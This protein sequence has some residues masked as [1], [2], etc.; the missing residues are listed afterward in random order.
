[1]QRYILGLS[2]VALTYL[3]GKALNLR[4]GC[5]LVADPDKPMVR[6][7]VFA[8]GTEKPFDVDHNTA[9]AYA[10]EAAKAFGVGEDRSAEFEAKAAKAALK[11]SGKKEEES[12][13]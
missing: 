8:D 2:L 13:E 10:A 11:K 3:D 12:A 6:A 5:Q 4:Q 1:L 7:L 9:T